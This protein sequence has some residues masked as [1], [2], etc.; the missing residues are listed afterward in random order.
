MMDDQQTVDINDVLSGRGNGAN[1]HPDSVH[2]RQIVADKRG[3]YR[4][5][6]RQGK[7]KIVEEVIG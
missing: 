5:S 7:Q 6:S 3:V 4:R 1:I 2:F